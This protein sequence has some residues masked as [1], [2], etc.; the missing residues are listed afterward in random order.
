MTMSSTQKLNLLAA[1]LMGML[2]MSGMRTQALAQEK[3]SDKLDFH[4]K[5]L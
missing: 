1:T 5:S 4:D 3:C 2:L